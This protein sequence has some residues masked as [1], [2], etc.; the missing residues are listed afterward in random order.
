MLEMLATLCGE[1]ADVIVYG[2]IFG[3]KVQD[4]DYGFE[5]AEGY[6]VFDIKIGGKYMDWVDVESF[7]YDFAVPTVPVIFHGPWSC[8]DKVI[9]AYAS[10]PTTVG[11]PVRK[12]KGREGIVIKLMRENPPRTGC[13]LGRQRRT[14]L[15]YLSADYL[16]RKGAQD[17]A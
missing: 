3:S 6:R 15:K 16:D 5:G 12:F 10:G 11:T 2:E 13:S 4:M 7:C 9:D 8:V 14:I 17:N 1:S